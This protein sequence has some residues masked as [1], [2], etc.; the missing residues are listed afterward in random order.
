MLPLS[1]PFPLS[2]LVSLY[3]PPRISLWNRDE[4]GTQP[5]SFRV[6]EAFAC[7][8]G[9]SVIES[10]WEARG[11]VLLRGAY[12]LI[13]HRE[14]SE[15]KFTFCIFFLHHWCLFHRDLSKLKFTFCMYFSCMSM[16]SPLC[17]V[18]LLLFCFAVL[19]FTLCYAW[20]CWHCVY[21]SSTTYLFLSQ[22]IST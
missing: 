7:L 1:I 18:R 21:I 4:R 11:W 3:L 16:M 17:K 19:D 2:S 12:E 15:P 10:F 20:V 8:L 22:Y 9:G 6:F 5:F 14:L 13:F